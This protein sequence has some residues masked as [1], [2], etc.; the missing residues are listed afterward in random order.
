LAAVILA[1]ALFAP[2]T[3]LPLNRLWEGLAGR[4]G[5]A[6]NYIILGLFLYLVLSPVS[7]T[8]KVFRRTVLSLRFDSSSRSYLEPVRRQFDATTM[9][10]MF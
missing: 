3:L 8:F 1:L 6:N 7:L 10:D 5:A 4:I 2:I 9:R